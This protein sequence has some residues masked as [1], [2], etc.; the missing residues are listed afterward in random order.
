MVGR[1]T[2]NKNAPSYL[3]DASQEQYLTPPLQPLPNTSPTPTRVNVGEMSTPLGN[4]SERMTSALDQTQVDA[5][6]KRYLDNGQ[7]KTAMFWADKRLVL[8]RKKDRPLSLVDVAEF[9][10]KGF[11]FPTEPVVPF[12]AYLYKTK[13]FLPSEEESRILDKMSSDLKLEAA[14]LILLGKTYLMTQNRQSARLCLQ[15]ALK[16]DCCAVEAMEII[17]KYDLLPKRNFDEIIDRF[18]Y[19]ECGIPN[20][21]VHFPIMDGRKEIKN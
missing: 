13:S 21:L 2:T 20:A 4:L 6:I 7:F 1:N 10:K 19:G 5:L 3:F 14:L 9:I 8:S 16:K 17:H 15:S 11:N 12:M 18:P